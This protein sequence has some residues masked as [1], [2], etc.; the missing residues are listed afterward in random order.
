LNFPSQFARHT[1]GVYESIL[2]A[3]TSCATGSKGIPELHIGFCSVTENSYE[4]L[5]GQ[6]NNKI[7]TAG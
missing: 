7:A 4:F 6:D 2:A 5:A 1:A 3:E